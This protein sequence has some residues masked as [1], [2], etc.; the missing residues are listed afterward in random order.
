MMPPFSLT[1]DGFE[2]QLGT[3]Y[4]GHFALTGLLLPLLLNTLSSRVVTLSSL[5]HQWSGI[6]FQDINFRNGYN[7]RK[8]YG[9]SKLACL[10]FA[11]EL[12]RRFKNVN[13]KTISVAAHPGLSDTNLAQHM[14]FAFRWL[15][16]LIGQSAKQGAQPTLYAA[17]SPSLTGGEYI[18]PDGFGEWRGKPI[19]VASNKASHD[20]ATSKKLWEL[21]EEMTGVKFDF[22]D[23]SIDLVL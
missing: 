20:A 4:L 14:P 6:Q 9:Q 19:I 7:K 11:Y 16:P 15:S 10:M 2:N 12:D 5:A 17:T 8:A 18:G 21:S 1:A 22:D 13:A 23:L 3:N